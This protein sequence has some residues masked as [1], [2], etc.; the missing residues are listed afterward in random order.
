[1]S[2]MRGGFIAN[3]KPRTANVE[4]VVTR[5]DGTVINLGR[6]SYYHRNKFM[7]FVGNKV[8]TVRRWWLLRTKGV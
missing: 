7:N 6:I 5:A 4:A 8:I 3:V 2:G 1:M